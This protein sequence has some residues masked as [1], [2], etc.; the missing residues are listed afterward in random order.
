[1]RGLVIGL[2]LLACG[3]PALHAEQGAR[4]ACMAA[5]AAVGLAAAPRILV[6]GGVLAIDVTG[7]GLGA[8]PGGQMP[9]PLV[10]QLQ[11]NPA[12]RAGSGMPSTAADALPGSRERLFSSLLTPGLP[13]MT[14]ST[15][16]RGE[17]ELTGF[18]DDSDPA[19]LLALVVAQGSAQTGRRVMIGLRSA[20][21]RA[22]QTA[23][24]HLYAYVSRLPPSDQF[25]FGIPSR[26]V[27][28]GP[29]D[30]PLQSHGDALAQIATWRA[31][32]VAAQPAGASAVAPRW[33]S[34]A[35]QPSASPVQPGD[36]GHEVSVVVQVDG[37]PTGRGTV[38]FTREPHLVCMAQVDPSGVARC[39]M[40]D[41][42][43]HEH[44]HDNEGDVTVATFSGA[45][46]G[47]VTLLPTTAAWR[48]PR[49]AFATRFD[50]QRPPAAR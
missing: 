28:G 39:R 6:D 2:L 50:L 38:T 37:T 8:A 14:V 48:L 36:D 22:A 25:V 7:H 27:A 1:M 16:R 29:A 32:A 19:A 34:V 26:I 47:D 46:G 5:S 9:P 49:P 24:E 43:F 13:S 33:Q 18:V 42:H 41:A 21:A 35:L 40:T 11:P 10:A 4:P 15:V 31:C 23:L 20:S 30:Q 3:V 12:A 17:L 44:R 45:T